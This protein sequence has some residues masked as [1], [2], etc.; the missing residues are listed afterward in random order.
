MNFG[1]GTEETRYELDEEEWFS[2][3]WHKQMGQQWCHLLRYSGFGG[4]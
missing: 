3:F 2:G 1:D 4:A